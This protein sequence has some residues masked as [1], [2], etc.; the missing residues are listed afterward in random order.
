MPARPLSSLGLR[1]RTSGEGDLQG[2]AAVSKYASS[3]I[4]HTSCA[5]GTSEAR[6]AGGGEVVVAAADDFLRKA[7]ARRCEACIHPG[8]A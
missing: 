2:S 7:S 1:D 5:Y 6:M 8:S 4:E 3:R